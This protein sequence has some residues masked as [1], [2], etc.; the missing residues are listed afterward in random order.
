MKKSII[1]ISVLSAVSVTSVYANTWDNPGDYQGDATL[2]WLEM[3]DGSHVAV[4]EIKYNRDENGNIV[5]ISFDPKNDTPDD[6]GDYTFETGENITNIGD[7]D[8]NLGHICNQSGS[9][10]AGNTCTVNIDKI[11]NMHGDIYIDGDKINP[12]DLKGDK[13]DRGEK[14][15]RGAD[16]RDGVD[17]VDGK[18]GKD[19]VDGQDGASA[20][21]KDNGDGNIELGVEGKEGEA[22]N[23]NDTFATDDDLADVREDVEQNASDIADTQQQLDNTVDVWVDGEGNGYGATLTDEH[24][25]S[26]GVASYDDV[27]ANREA[28]N[29]NTEWDHRQQDQI[30]GNTANIQ[31]LSDYTYEE[32]DNLYNTKMDKKDFNAYTVYQ[33][34]VDSRQDRKLGILNSRVG[35]LENDITRL[36]GMI[37]AQQ[38]ANSIILPSNFNGNLAVGVGVGYYAG[39]NGLSLGVVHDGGDYAVKVTASGTDADD[40]EDLAY[41]A[42][43]NFTF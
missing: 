27:K 18:D 25:N 19:G 40:W 37:A 11:E 33:S 21:V 17:G 2:T 4:D 6:F 14:G 13:G 20:Y 12:E 32:I 30:N 26:V 28:I 39:H 29:A 8:V 42:S 22:I 34:E 24:G 31:S 23:L 5:S 10:G 15:D 3:E 36:D 16:G 9:N 7:I 35:Q 1:A 41:G 43:V 38:A